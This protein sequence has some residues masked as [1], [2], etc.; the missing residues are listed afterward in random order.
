M[1]FRIIWNIKTEIINETEIII[2]L[3][4]GLLA[5]KI[6]WDSSIMIHTALTIKQRSR[7]QTF[8]HCWWI[9]VAYK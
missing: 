6:I 8:L 3:Q 1:Q 2:R 7:F 9:K 5:Q 4:N